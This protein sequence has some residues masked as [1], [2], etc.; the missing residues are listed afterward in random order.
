[1]SVARRL[2]E[3]LDIEAVPYEVIPHPLAFTAQGVAAAA[4]VPGRNLA[5]SVIVKG[6][7]GLA[8][9]V[10]PANH[11]VDIPAVRETLDGDDYRLASEAEFEEAFPEC[12]VG[13]MPPFGNLYGMPVIVAEPLIWDEEIYF[14]C[15][16]HTEVIRMK[17]ADY[18]RL[19]SPRVASV[20]YPAGAAPMHHSY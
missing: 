6:A 20:S 14:N 5:K 18:A 4:H 19:V 3:Y 12:E 10:L 9:A 13:A 15:G 2:K 8:M 16:N 7:W 1:M 17:Y 11:R